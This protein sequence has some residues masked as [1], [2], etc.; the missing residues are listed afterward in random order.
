MPNVDT[1][2]IDAMMELERDFPDHC[3]A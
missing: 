1:D 3:I 2:S